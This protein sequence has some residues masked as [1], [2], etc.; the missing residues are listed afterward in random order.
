LIISYSYTIASFMFRLDP[1]DNDYIA[2]TC[3]RL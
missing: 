3:F 2:I 1:A